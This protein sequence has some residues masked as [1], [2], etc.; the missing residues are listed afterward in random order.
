MLFE[1][2]QGVMLDIDHGTYPYV[3]SSHAAVGGIVTGSGLAPKA[4]GEVIGIVKAYTT[5]VG[6]GPFVTELTGVKG[7][8]LRQ[9]GGEFGATTGRP[10]RCGW[11]D[12]VV[13]GYAC[14]VGGVDNIALTK[15]DVLVAKKNYRSVLATNCQSGEVTTAI[16]ADL[17][18]LG[19]VQPVYEI[20]PGWSEDI[21]GVCDFSALPQAAQDYVRFIEARCGVRV[22]YIGTGPGREAIIV[23]A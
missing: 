18:D 7:D 1:G 12:L 5:R 15:L 9:R 17:D 11:L 23:R 2:A 14:R 21:A 6:E 3:T 4:L 10:R 22:G 13:V 19:H 8:D 16:P 20:L